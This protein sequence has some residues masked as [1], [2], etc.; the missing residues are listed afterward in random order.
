ME[1]SE[2]ALGLLRDE[3]YAYLCRETLK[4]KLAD[5]EREKATIASTRPPFGVLARRETR[6]AFTQSMRTALDNEAALRERL[7]QVERLE[8]WLQPM[9][10][11]EITAYLKV[12]SPDYHR[13]AQIRELLSTWANVFAALPEL[14]LG[15]ARDLKVFREE[16][17][18]GASSG[19]DR[20]QALAVLRETASRVEEQYNQLSLSAQ[21]LQQLT[22]AHADLAREIRLPALP[23]L[24]RA[25]WVSQLALMPLEQCLKETRQVETD[26]REFLTSGHAAAFAR[27][28]ASHSAC[29]HLEQRFL[30]YYWNQ[31]RSHAQT[32]YVQERDIDDVLA[33]LAQRYV[34]SDILRHQ[35]ALTRDPFVSER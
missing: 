27:V 22:Q 8:D 11:E 30:Q 26:V 25:G 17:A 10:R 15:F 14:L 13:F 32:H 31:L 7:T 28:E 16:T 12:A 19:R 4:E 6:D 23:D 3:A 9:I 1:L 35:K 18:S 24:R 29:T 20:V 5:L 2:T 33:E 21:A 34:Q